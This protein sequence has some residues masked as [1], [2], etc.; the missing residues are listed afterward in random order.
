MGRSEGC[1]EMWCFWV[2]CVDVDMVV[3]NVGCGSDVGSGGSALDGIG[4]GQGN[5]E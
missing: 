3:Q 2:V 4:G 1:E 5:L